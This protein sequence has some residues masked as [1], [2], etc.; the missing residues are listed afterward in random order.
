[1]NQFIFQLSHDFVEEIHNEKVI[2]RMDLINHFK[3]WVFKPWVFNFRTWVFKH[4]IFKYWVFKLWIFICWVFRHWISKILLYFSLTC[5][6]WFLNWTFKLIFT[7][8]LIPYHY[9]F[10][11]IDIIPF[12][13]Q[14][15]QFIS[16][17]WFLDLSFA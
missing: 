15:L 17:S 12:V 10:L 11:T 6:I 13:S 16:E 2:Q 3:Y 9:I 5:S 4:W 14:L 1:M 8:F 7:I